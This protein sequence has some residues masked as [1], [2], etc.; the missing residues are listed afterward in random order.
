MSDK[1]ISVK[2]KLPPSQGYYLVAF[3]WCK[4]FTIDY[5]YF[6]GKSKW[7]R[8]GNNITHWHELPLPPKGDK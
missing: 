1:W 2:D 6:R 4:Q 3:R 5:V 7:A 8:L